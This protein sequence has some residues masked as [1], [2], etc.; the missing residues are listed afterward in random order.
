M[1]VSSSQHESWSSRLAFLMASIGAAVGLGNIW[2][3]P[4]TLGSAGG[5][6]FVVVYLIAVFVVAMPIMMGEMVIGRRGRMS[7]PST[8]RKLAAESGAVARVAG[9]RLD[10]SAGRVSGLQFL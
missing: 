7:A 1:Q 2:K 4:Y 10:G 9:S 3:F 8:M 6:A 5:S